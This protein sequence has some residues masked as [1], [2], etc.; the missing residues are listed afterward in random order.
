MGKGRVPAAAATTMSRTHSCEE[1][2][3]CISESTQPPLE[4]DLATDPSYG[5]EVG[6]QKP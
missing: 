3:T 6:A 5:E 4:A 2:V 1:Q